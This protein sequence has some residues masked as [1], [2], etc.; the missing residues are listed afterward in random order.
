MLRSA[1]QSRLLQNVKVFSEEIL[2]SYREFVF[3]SLRQGLTF[4]R[5]VSISSLLWSRRWPWISAFPVPTSWVLGRQTVSC[6]IWFMRSQVFNLHAKSTSWATSSAWD[7]AFEENQ[8]ICMKNVK[9]GKLLFCWYSCL[10]R[11]CKRIPSLTCTH[12]NHSIPKHLYTKTHTWDLMLLEPH[13]N[14]LWP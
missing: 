10:S 3:L 7:K 9:M 14:T 1:Q 12:G 5:M 2:K 13:L 6:H 4:P 8:F 11:E